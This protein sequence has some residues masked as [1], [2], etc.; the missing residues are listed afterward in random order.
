MTRERFSAHEMHERHVAAATEYAVLCGHGDPDPLKPFLAIVHALLAIDCSLERIAS[1]LHNTPR[2]NLTATLTSE[3]P[4]SPALKPL[5]V[6]PGFAV[7]FATNYQDATGKPATPPSPLV[8]NNDNPAAIALTVAADGLSA[9]A[10][11]VADGAAN[12]TVT[13]PSSTA[14]DSDQLV[15]VEIPLI[16]LSA[17]LVPDV[18]APAAG[19]DAAAAGA[20]PAWDGTRHV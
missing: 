2:I 10:R 5:S 9:T 11:R 13:D 1:A 6:P 19:A 16:N 18:P 14:E 17:T 12:I 4:M 3:D 20:A 15:V 7:A 8:W